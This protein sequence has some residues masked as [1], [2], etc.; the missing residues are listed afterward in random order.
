MFPFWRGA[1]RGLITWLLK[2]EELCT[3]A[4]LTKDPLLL[5]KKKKGKKKAFPTHTASSPAWS[6]EASAWLSAL[7]TLAMYL[8]A[9]SYASLS[10]FPYL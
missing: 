5:Q 6:P 3:A 2:V 1:Y 4:S 10:L 7:L 8:W 9:G